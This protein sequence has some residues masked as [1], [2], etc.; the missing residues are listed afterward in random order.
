MDKN[1]NGVRVTNREI[2]DN[3][4]SFKD[5]VRQKFEAQSAELYR[6]KISIR[7]GLFGMSVAALKILTDLGLLDVASAG[8]P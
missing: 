7:V 1:G 5:E 6:L 8:T 4:T 2:Y 3:L